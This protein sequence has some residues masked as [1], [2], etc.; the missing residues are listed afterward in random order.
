MPDGSASPP[1]GTTFT[2]HGHDAA[3][4]ALAAALRDDRLHHAYL[5]TGPAHVGKMTLAVQLAQAVTCAEGNDGCRRR[6]A[7]GQH[8][9]VRVLSIDS[10]A[11]E[12]PRTVIGIESIRDVINAAYLQPYESR[13]RVFIIDSADRMSTDAAN[14]LLKVLEE[15]PGH[16]LLL[17]L[18]DN[19]DGVLP[20][21]RSRCQHLDLRPLP[22]DN[23]AAILRNEAGMGEEQAM[24]LSRLSRGCVG[25]ALQAAHDPSLLAGVHQQ[26][27]RITDVIGGNLQE[28]FAYAEVLA[29]QF[30]RDRA[31][32]RAELYLW[33][34]WFRD[35][36]LVQQ[37]N[38]EMITNV[39]WRETIGLHANA[40]TTR[41]TVK[42]V[43]RTMETIEALDKNVNP[44]LALEAL[45]LDAPLLEL[46]DT[47]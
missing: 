18:S 26:L 25:W 35:I 1:A 28:R 10:E 45:M 27:E 22:V 13:G 38:G 36:L 43:R 23:V 47:A 37:G 40:L 33:L 8:P 34:R 14:A 17:L 4:S 31:A 21:V 11:A 41:Q 3:V 44:R 46:P 24:V 16:V 20:T 39:S 32:G 7:T 5:F 30:Q 2:L 12:G 29:R 15:P 42:W 9:D 6:V 19:E